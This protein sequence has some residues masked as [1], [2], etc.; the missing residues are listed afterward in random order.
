MVSVVRVSLG[1]LRLPYIPHILSVNGR[2][3]HQTIKPGDEAK[4]YK[5]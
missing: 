1:I 4:L 3:E 2:S 5:L